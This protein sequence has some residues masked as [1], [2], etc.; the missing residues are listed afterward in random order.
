MKVAKLNRS[1]ERT[2]AALLEGLGRDIWRE[3][4][5]LA[6]DGSTVILR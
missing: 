4:C 3:V 5:Q 1:T 2:S 6:T